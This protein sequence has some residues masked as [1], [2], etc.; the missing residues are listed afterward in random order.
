MTMHVVMDSSHIIVGRSPGHGEQDCHAPD[1]GHSAAHRHQRIH[2][3]SA[4]DESPES[5]DEEFLI[6]DHDNECQDSFKKR[7][8]DG[9]ALEK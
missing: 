6:D 1:I 7:D 8:S 4:M 5:A 3:R 9:I 2:I